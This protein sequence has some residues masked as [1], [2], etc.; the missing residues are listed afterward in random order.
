MADLRQ[1]VFDTG[2]IVAAFLKDDDRHVE[3]AKFLASFK[4]RPF[5]PTTVMAGVSAMLESH[6]ATEAAFLRAV[7]NGTFT[8]VPIEQPDIAR[9]IE[10]EEQYADFPLGGVDASVA[11]IAERLKVDAIATIDHRHFH[12]IRP[13]KGTNFELVP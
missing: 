10:L 2:V 11:A 6:P 8:L 12:A 1:V 5:L 13:R 7:A 4:G 3:C 9:M